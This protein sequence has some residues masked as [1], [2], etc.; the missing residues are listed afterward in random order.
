MYLGVDIHQ[1]FC[2]TTVM[3]S[4][5]RTI[6]RAKVPTDR[7]HLTEFFARYSG[8]AAAI[9]SNTIWEFVYETLAGLGLEVTLASPVQLKAIAQARV[10]TDTY[11]GSVAGDSAFLSYIDAPLSSGRSR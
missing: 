4:Q 7:E 1:K 10:K 6:E 2:Q 5:G 3:D 8:S 11:D 9:E